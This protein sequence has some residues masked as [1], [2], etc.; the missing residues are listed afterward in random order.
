MALKKFITSIYNV[1]VGF[2]AILLKNS[3]GISWWCG[4]FQKWRPLSLSLAVLST[5]A[6]IGV[7]HTWGTLFQKSHHMRVFWLSSV[8]IPTVWFGPRLHSKVTVNAVE[9]LISLFYLPI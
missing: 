6:S 8:N 2:H 9:L 7:H 4:M 1:K 3:R 5:A